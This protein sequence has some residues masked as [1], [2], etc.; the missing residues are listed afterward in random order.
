MSRHLLTS[1]RKCVIY[2]SSVPV[3]NI[4]LPLCFC[5]WLDWVIIPAKLNE[6]D[7]HS[8]FLISLTSDSSPPPHPT[9]LVACLPVVSELFRLSNLTAERLAD[10]SCSLLRTGMDRHVLCADMYQLHSICIFAIVNKVMLWFSE[11]RHLSC[12]RCVPTSRGTFYRELRWRHMFLRNVGAPSFPPPLPPHQRVG[13]S[14]VKTSDFK[15]YNF[16]QNLE[17]SSN[18]K[19]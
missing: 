7:L 16:L 9:P 6:F 8:R 4:Q 5:F 11:L 18:V 17:R 1:V 10:F 15:I 2:Q 3:W 14:V 19:A 12:G 13:V